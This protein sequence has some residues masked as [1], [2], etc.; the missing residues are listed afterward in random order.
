VPW[1]TDTYTQIHGRLLT[2]YTI[3]SASWANN[4]ESKWL[5]R[6]N[7]A[8]GTY[9]SRSFRRP[10]LL[11]SRLCRYWRVT[12]KDGIMTPYHRS[13]RNTDAHQ[14]V[15]RQPVIK[16]CGDDRT[17][18]ASESNLLDWLCDRRSGYVMLR[19]K[20]SRT[21]VVFGVCRWTGQWLRA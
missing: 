12:T 16:W 4:N 14:Y 11:G 7:V 9:C 21:V 17:S 1:L 13:R 19:L 5:S 20:C 10:V 15:R 3:S 8:L 2:G 18:C 6:V